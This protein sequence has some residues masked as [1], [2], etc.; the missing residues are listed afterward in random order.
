MHIPVYLPPHT[1]F[2]EPISRLSHMHY[3]DVV[4]NIIEAAFLSEPCSNNNGTISVMRI[5]LLIIVQLALDS[6]NVKL[7]LGFK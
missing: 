1:V 2:D 5:I 3:Y 4:Y 6:I 7:H